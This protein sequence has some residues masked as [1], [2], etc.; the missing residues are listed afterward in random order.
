MRLGARASSTCKPFPTYELRLGGAHLNE[1]F[2]VEL[3][4]LKNLEHLTLSNCSLSREA[5]QVLARLGQLRQLELC[6]SKLDA[7][8]L[9]D[10]QRTLPNCRIVT[11]T[12]ERP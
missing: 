6:G 1:L 4:G 8:Q 12:S 11:A 9:A 5:V 2:F 7:K 10:L 3:A